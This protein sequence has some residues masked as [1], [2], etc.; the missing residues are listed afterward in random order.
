MQKKYLSGYVG[1]MTSWDVR[2][3]FFEQGLTLS[4][5]PCKA[6]FSSMASLNPSG[7][8]EFVLG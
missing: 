4:T 3:P 2:L 8:L 1:A 6:K 7:F 5:C